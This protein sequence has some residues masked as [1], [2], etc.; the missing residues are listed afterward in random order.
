MFPCGVYK[1]KVGKKRLKETGVT[2]PN[3]L[4]DAHYP[5]AAKLGHGTEYK[6]AHAYDK[7]YV[8]QQYLPD[9]YVGT[10]FYQPTDNGYEK[11]Q[12]RYLEWIKE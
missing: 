2:I 7:H 10:T 9:E 4:K 8:A 1:K 12:R 11:E 5:G 6:Y 3:H